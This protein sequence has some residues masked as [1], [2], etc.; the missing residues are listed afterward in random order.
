MRAQLKRLKKTKLKHK[1]SQGNL[2]RNNNRTICK[3][4]KSKLNRERTIIIKKAQNKVW[5]IKKN[6]ESNL[7]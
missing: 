6:K 5:R 3:E 4:V 7:N 2:L 1:Y